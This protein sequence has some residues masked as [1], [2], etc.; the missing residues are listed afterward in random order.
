MTIQH[1]RY[2][3][4]VA[5]DARNNVVKQGIID[6]HAKALTDEQLKSIVELYN[7]KIET[8]H[9]DEYIEKIKS[10]EYILNCKKPYDAFKIIYGLGCAFLHLDVMD[11][12]E[13]YVF[14]TPDEKDTEALFFARTFLMPESLFL[15]D[16]VKQ[17]GT[18]GM[19][20][21]FK[22]ADIYNV[23]YL[24]VIARGNDLRCWNPHTP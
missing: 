13:T 19:C 1:K 21:V 9:D 4:K 22:I 8:A 14:E 16:V 17:T 11:P 18:D 7:G 23:D 20:N 12:N 15:L 3:E 6:F 5:M 24:H 2:I 10:S